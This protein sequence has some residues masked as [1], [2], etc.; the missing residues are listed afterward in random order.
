MWARVIV[1]EAHTIRNRVTRASKACT[2]LL[3]A[4][5]WAL[6]GTPIVNRLSDLYSLLRFLRVEPWGDYSFFK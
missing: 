2:E 3:A 5:R 6:T 1:D 4:R